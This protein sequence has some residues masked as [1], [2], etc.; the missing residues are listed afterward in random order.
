MVQDEVCDNSIEL[1]ASE[2]QARQRGD[3]HLRIFGSF[4]GKFHHARV[5]IHGGYRRSAPARGHRDSA[6]AGTDIKHCDRGPYRG[7]IEQ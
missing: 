7:R 1:L 4:P 6:R 2:R 5:G 3:A